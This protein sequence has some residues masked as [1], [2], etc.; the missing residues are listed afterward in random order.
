MA[1]QYVNLSDTFDD[2]RQKYNNVATWQGVLDD[3][4]TSA[5]SDLV[6][7]I[8]SIIT[9]IAALDI[10]ASCRV[11]TSGTTLSAT[12]SA[13]TL[14]NNS[15]QTALRIDGIGLAVDERVLVKDQTTGSQNG[16]YTVTDV[17]GDNSNWILTRATDFNSSAE[18][19]AG[20]FM[21]IAEGNTHADEGFLLTTNDVITLDTTSLTFTSFTSVSLS[22]SDESG[23]TLSGTSLWVNVDDVTIEIADN[24]LQVRDDGIS[25]DKIHRDVA[26]TGLEQ[27]TDGSLSPDLGNGL[28]FTGNE[29]AIDPSGLAG[30]GLVQDG[31]EL[32]VNTD[33]STLTIISDQVLIADSGVTSIKLYDDI[34]IRGVFSIHADDPSDQDGGDVTIYAEETSSPTRRRWIGINSA[35]P[36]GGVWPPDGTKSS[37]ANGAPDSNTGAVLHIDAAVDI[38][39]DNS[40]A[41]KIFRVQGTSSRDAK[42]RQGSQLFNIDSTNNTVNVGRRSPGDSADESPSAAQKDREI[43]NVDGAIQIRKIFPEIVESSDAQG[44]LFIAWAESRPSSSSELYLGEEY[45]TYKDPRS[46]AAGVD[47]RDGHIEDDKDLL[48]RYDPDVQ[49]GETVNIT[50]STPRAWAKIS[51]SEGVPSLDSSYNIRTIEDVETGHIKLNFVREMGNTD[52]VI[53]GQTHDT[54]DPTPPTTGLPNPIFPSVIHQEYCQII[55]ENNN[56]GTAKDYPHTHVVILGEY[57]I[58]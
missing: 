18:I 56:T 26:G 25:A 10:K 2:W 54:L 40:S 16:I 39:R 21:F 22:V 27:N 19:T 47:E 35:D 51:I 49:G 32:D 45:N 6:S 38:N 58:S 11:A 15:E 34:D 33:G 48:Y 36:F 46:G 17:G 23:L 12:Y 24:T 52:Y 3:L 43:F 50:R 14:T 37:T 7:A 13:N 29:I 8:N 4:T 53:I 44:K 55:L 41:A 57:G 9:D 42:G 20:A 30:D 28:Q 31:T 1:I 5:T